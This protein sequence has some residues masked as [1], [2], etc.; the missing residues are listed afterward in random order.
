VL[1]GLKKQ[2]KAPW[3][4]LQRRR[5]VAELER[6]E[7]HV[8]REQLAADLR[9]LGIQVGD[10]LFVHSSLKSLGF[11]QGGPQAVIDALRDAVGPTGT[12]LLPAY[13]IPGGTLLGTCELEGYV[14]DPRA[15]GTH[16]GALPGTLLAQPGVQRSVHPTHSCA[17]IGPLAAHLTEAHHLAPSVFGEGSPWQR[18]AALAQGKVLGLGISMG[19]VTYYHRLED[20]LGEAFPEPVWLPRTYR[21]PCLTAQGARVEVPVRPFDPELA[22]WRIDQKPRADLRDWFAAE[23]ERAGLKRN[24]RV[25]AA[26]SWTIEGVAFLN[27][28]RGLAA[29]GITIY[30]RPEQLG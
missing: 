27:H 16:M 20:E 21:L 24:G 14:F 28:L 17:A 25:G 30:S 9:A 23:F 1:E 29:R 22:K 26:Q 12:L 13:W 15:H 7:T 6:S 18:F 10:A 5:R 4:A 11:V 3:Q 19:P 2:L 8:G